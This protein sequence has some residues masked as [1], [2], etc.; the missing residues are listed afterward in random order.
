MDETIRHNKENVAYK[1][2]KSRVNAD[3]LSNILREQ[4]KQK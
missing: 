3:I 2:E 4:I 1:A